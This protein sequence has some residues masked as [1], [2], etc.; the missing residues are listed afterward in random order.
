MW[1]LF[2]LF[3][4]YSHFLWNPVFLIVPQIVEK[5]VN[6]IISRYSI[7]CFCC[8][9]TQ[10]FSTFCSPK[11]CSTPGF[12]VF[13]YLPEFWSDS[14]PLSEWGRPAISSSVVP[15]SSCLQSFPASGSFLMNR[16]FESGSQ[17]F[18]TS[19]SA[20]VL[21]MNIRDWLPL[22]LTGLFLQS[23]G[24]SR[25][26]SSSTVQIINSLVLSRLDG[27]TLISVHDY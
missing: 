3:V 9:V 21:P 8:S 10:L 14:R 18:R 13:H 2:L 25:G 19:A 22:G 1:V 27:P 7:G 16:L 24:L 6:P 17:S 4:I 26:F 15:F 5:E 11:D 20:W 23:K 12:L